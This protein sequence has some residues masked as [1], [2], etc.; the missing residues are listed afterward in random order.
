M[1]IRDELLSLERD[2]VLVAEEAVSWAA[3]HPSS[4]LHKALEWDNKKAGHE[5][6]LE[7]MRKL[8]RIHIVNDEGIRQ[9]VSLSI[10]RTKEGGGYRPLDTVI[11]TPSMR[12]VLLDDALKELD[13]LRAKYSMLSELARVW[14][15]TEKAKKAR[16][17]K[18]AKETKR[19]VLKRNTASHI[20]A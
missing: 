20:E 8:I 1:S 11:A 13:R 7:Q 16:L 2:G 6:R 12:I 18:T 5:Y 17:R 19:G 10:D 15:E 3:D 4:D 14:D 9:V